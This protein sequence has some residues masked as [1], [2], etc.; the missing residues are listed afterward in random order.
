MGDLR[1]FLHELLRISQLVE[2]VGIE[3]VATTIRA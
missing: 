1:N 3:L 2:K